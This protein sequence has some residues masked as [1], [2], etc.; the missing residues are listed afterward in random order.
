ML[1]KLQ[2]SSPRRGDDIW[3]R[4]WEIL[5]K[6]I[7]KI[8]VKWLGNSPW[9]SKSL[10][11]WLENDGPR[12]KVPP[13]QRCK[14]SGRISTHPRHS[15]WVVGH[16]WSHNHHQCRALDGAT[17]HKVHGWLV[18][19]LAPNAWAIAHGWACGILLRMEEFPCLAWGTRIVPNSCMLAQNCMN[20]TLWWA[21]MTIKDVHPWIRCAHAWASACK[22]MMGRPTNTMPIRGHGWAMHCLAGTK[23]G[24]GKVHGLV[25]LVHLSPRITDSGTMHRPWNSFMCSP[26]VGQVVAHACA[27]KAQLLG[28]HHLSKGHEATIHGVVGLQ[29]LLLL[30]RPPRITDSVACGAPITQWSNQEALGFMD[31]A[32]YCLLVVLLAHNAWQPC[33]ELCLPKFNLGVHPTHYMGAHLSPRILD[34]GTMVGW[35]C[36]HACKASTLDAW[37]QI[38]VLCMDLCAQPTPCP[39]EGMDGQAIACWLCSWRTMHGNPAMVG[40]AQICMN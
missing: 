19:L 38:L 18:V 2:I 29:E 22:F 39:Y 10:Y 25:V 40:L 26:C 35:P 23:L 31:G 16:H 14:F 36:N 15:P 32:G 7:F 37:A 33:H 12:C 24:L 8:P 17:M 30:A 11:I 1:E 20:S 5:G 4:N 13:L 27:T 3:P 34:S 6:N 28:A 21:C 9:I